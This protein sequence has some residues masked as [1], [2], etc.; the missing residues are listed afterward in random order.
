MTHTQDK[1][2][3]VP[4]LL[5]GSENRCEG[6]GPHPFLKTGPDNSSRCELSALLATVFTQ[7]PT[8]LVIAPAA[9]KNENLFSK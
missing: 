6:S 9:R 4:S 5:Q 7:G 1:Q 3:N 8:S 2:K